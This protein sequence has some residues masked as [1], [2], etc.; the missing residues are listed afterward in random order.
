MAKVPNASEGDS[1]FD[2]EA[3][4]RLYPQL[5]RRKE[6][7]RTW[8]EAHRSGEDPKPFRF[9]PW[10]RLGESEEDYPPPESCSPE[11]GR[12]LYGK[13]YDLWKLG[14]PL[15]FRYSVDF[16]F[17]SSFHDAEWESGSNFLAEIGESNSKAQSREERAAEYEKKVKKPLLRKAR[18][19]LTE[20]QSTM[21]KLIGIEERHPRYRTIYSPDPFMESPELPEL[22]GLK[23]LAWYGKSRLDRIGYVKKGRRGDAIKNEMLKRL[24]AL[25]MGDKRATAVL[26]MLGLEG[27]GDAVD[28]V[29]Q[30]RRRQK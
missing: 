13:H 22:K 9:L 5:R 19:L 26:K 30:R 25:G 8:R 29:R 4:Y 18:K 24:R 12:L 14:V 1:V 28:R 17:P 11:D 2:A 21:E 7:M 3:F 10:L 6:L 23:S 15:D 16:V 27:A 20:L